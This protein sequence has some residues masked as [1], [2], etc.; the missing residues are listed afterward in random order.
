MLWSGSATPVTLERALSA[1]SRRGPRS[2]T[3]SYDDEYGYPSSIV[4]DWIEDAVDDEQDYWV[5]SF[6][7]VD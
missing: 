6:E 2:G 1:S 5:D 7:P 3:I 4:I